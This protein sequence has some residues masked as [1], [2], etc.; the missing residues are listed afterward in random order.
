MAKQREEVLNGELGRLLIA[1]HPGWNESNVH[2]DSTDTIRENRGLKIDVLV[3]DP[4]GQP[5]AIETKFAA[6]G[7]AAALREQVEGR[8]GLTADQTGSII[9]AGISV[10]YPDGTTSSSLEDAR[11]SYAVHQQGESEATRWPAG[12]EWLEGSLNDLADAVETATLSERRIREGQERLSDGVRDASSR[13]P[14]EDAAFD[15]VLH[16]GR[17]DQTTRMAVAIV[18]N[19]FVFHYAIEGQDGIPSVDAGSAKGG[20][21]KGRVVSAWDMILAVNYW[22]VF[23]IAKAIIEATPTRR[24]NPLLNAANNIAV[25]L[26]EVGATT[27]HDLAARMFQ[28]LIAD[29]KFLA[30]FYTLP[31]SAALLA[32]LAV[33][34]LTVD[35]S[36]EAAVA[37]LKVADFACGT[38]TLLSAVQRVMY[39]RLRR[40]GKDDR[41]FHQTFME[42]VLLGTDIMPSAAHLTASM[43]SSAHPGSRYGRSLIRV[44]P[45]GIDEALSKEAKRDADTPYIG[46]LDLRGEEFG[47][48]IFAEQKWGRGIGAQVQIGGSGLTATGADA[49]EG[50]ELGRD[51]PVEH[52]SFDLVI[53]NPPFTRPTNHE[54]GLDVPVPSFAGFGKSEDEQHA[55]SAKLRTTDKLFGHGNA[56]LS[57]E[58]M[59]LAHDKLKPGGVLALVLPFSFVAGQ[60]WAKARKGL[61]SW[62]DDVQVV[63]IATTGNAA[64]AFSADTGMAECLVLAKRRKQERESW[65]FLHVDYSNL[66]RRPGTLIE[67]HDTA[68]SIQRAVGRMEGTLADSGAAGILDADV[69][70]AMIGLRAGT[71]D[72]PRVGRRYR[73][74]MTAM[75]ELAERGLVHRDI[76]GAGG[77][78]AFDIRKE[79]GRGVATYPALWAHD[80]DKERSLIVEPDSRGE[81]RA[82]L[83]DRAK[84]TWQATSSRLHQNLDFQV[85]SQSLAMCFTEAPCIGGR[86]WPNLRPRDEAHELPLLLWSNTTLGLM[87]HWWSGT[88][89]QMGRSNLTVTAIP[90]LPTL[91]VKA[92]DRRQLRAFAKLFDNFRT[93]EFLPANEAYRDDARKE[94]DAG[95]LRI[96]NLRD[97][98][99]D[100]FDLLRLKWCSEPS[101]H[102]GK[103][104]RPDYAS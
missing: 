13:L 88:R 102:G 51:F 92:L 46:A 10:V 30:T 18:V 28:T 24:A 47:R 38:G 104:T 60:A 45:Y 11:L 31:E 85:N 19:A 59:D 72:L 63:S 98:D 86:A 2:I 79:K 76:N 84:V 101:V 50:R 43:L 68:R 67:A 56:G 48:G 17:G 70:V 49:R 90:D 95:V 93:R 73:V 16:Q 6:P 42:H 12:E 5:V 40:A 75:G 71:L 26:V 3:E 87:L 32:E 57:S 33:S 97:D 74:P 39:R 55:M 96:L 94:L 69:G 27:F 89:Q 83:Q 64:R 100:A 41:L 15:H 20:F 53:M 4:G 99:F 78:G 65:S 61:E 77:R 7:V 14:I 35:W 91:N 66:A 21:Q 36:D 34:R 62:Y 29:R 22:P 82:G 1:R 9:E 80:A 54:A 103:R 37:A 25:E 52:R 58:F 8:M 44:M 81:V 23:S